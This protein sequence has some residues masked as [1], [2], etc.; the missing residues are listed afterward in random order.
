MSTFATGI[1]GPTFIAFAPIPEPSSAV[2]MAAAGGS[3]ILRRRWSRAYRSSAR[4]GI[5]G[6]ISESFQEKEMNPK[7]RIVKPPVAPR[8]ALVFTLLCAFTVTPA[9]AALSFVQNFGSAGS[10]SGQFS[11]PIGVTVDSAGNVY[12][13][14]TSNNRIARFNP[15]NFAGTFTSYG[16]AGSGSGQFSTPRGVALDSAGNLY[17]ADRGN[18]RIDSFNPANFAGTFASFGSFGSAS[19]QFIYPGGVTLDSAGNVYVAD[20]LNNRID[21][22]NPANFAGTFT[23]FGSAGS[24][25]GQFNTPFVVSVDS[26]GM[27]MSPTPATIGSTVSIRRT[28]RAPSPPSAAKGPATGSLAARPVSPWTARGMSMSPT[29]TTTGSWSWRSPSPPPP[30]CWPPSPG[31]SS[32]AADGAG[33]KSFHDQRRCSVAAVGGGAWRTKPKR[34]IGKGRDNAIQTTP[35]EI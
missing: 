28:S 33:R 34:Q 20:S 5:L 25:S 17:V 1:S 21:R 16:S 3:L 19:G 11:G 15:A 22:F 10:G 23:S 2:L 12:V 29:S 27:S 26:A 30:S 35:D 4:T 6:G 7:T 24:G 31:R 9:R 18:S 14:D 8:I 32:S 13:G